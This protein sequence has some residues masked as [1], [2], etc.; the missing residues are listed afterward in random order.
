VGNA[1]VDDIG[2]AGQ[3][4]LGGRE[5]PCEAA[6]P[7]ALPKVENVEAGPVMVTVTWAVQ[8]ES[9]DE[10]L[11]LAG[12][13][14]RLRRRTGAGSWR[15]YRQADDPHELLETFIVGSWAEH[16]RQHARM[17]PAETAVIDRLEQTLLPGKPRLVRHS[18]A[19]SIGHRFIS[20]HDG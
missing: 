6:E 2:S 3:R 11:E 14:R 5:H 9:L 17:Y 12:E 4:Y 18:L 1:L 7:W 15:L 16:E 10:F 19:V 20:N 8:P 13:L